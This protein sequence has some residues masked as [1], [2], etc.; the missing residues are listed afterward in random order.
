MYALAREVVFFHRRDKQMFL[1][2]S[3]QPNWNSEMLKVTSI[4]L[5]LRATPVPVINSRVVPTKRTSLIVDTPDG[6]LPPLTPDGER[7]DQERSGRLGPD[8]F[9]PT[10]LTRM[11]RHTCTGQAKKCRPNP[12]GG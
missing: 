1:R 4:D 5:P 12:S 10:S 3:K 6:R 9:G 7:R 8:A 2:I 11:P